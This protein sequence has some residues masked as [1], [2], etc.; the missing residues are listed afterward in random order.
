MR[1]PS[2]AGRVI[3]TIQRGTRLLQAAPSPIEP[4]T[5]GSSPLAERGEP[6]LP[7]PWQRAKLGL[8]RAGNRTP[9]LVVHLHTNWCCT[10]VRSL[11]RYAPAA[12][13]AI[14]IQSMFQIWE[15]SGFYSAQIS[16]K[17]RDPASP[18]RAW[19]PGAGAHTH[20]HTHTHTRTHTHAHTQQAHTRPEWESISCSLVSLPF[21]PCSS[22]QG[23]CASQ[24]LSSWLAAK[25]TDLEWIAWSNAN[26][27]GS[28][29]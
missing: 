15:D 9:V 4:V 16:T 20:T 17:L 1:P 10:K 18:H 8:G 3:L 13:T 23:S 21:S 5:P 7:L 24:W 19:R 28:I 22:C 26:I 6:I 14:L 27:V 11:S 2:P 12:Q 29:D 25:T